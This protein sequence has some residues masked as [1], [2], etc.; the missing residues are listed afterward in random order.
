MGW[1]RSGGFGQA[2]L[3]GIST[4]R[5]ATLASAFTFLILAVAAYWP[6]TP[7]NSTHLPATP[8]GGY[9]FGD[10]A[11]MTWFLAWI[12]YAI[13]HGLNVFHTNYLDFPHGVNLAANTLSPLLGL[14]G[15]PVTLTLGPVATF[16]VLLRLA[17]ASSAFSM[18]W[19]LRHRCPWSISFVGGLAYGFGPYV[20]SQAQTHL[21]LAFVPLP[22]LILW[23]V[24]ELLVVRNRRPRRL[25]VVLGLL[26]GAQAL[27]DLELLVLLAILVIVGVVGGAVAARS[28]WRKWL[29]P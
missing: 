10:P 15:M 14:I 22:P 18:Y 25:G 24:Y 23:C 20:V 27:I 7:W 2:L 11:Q 26:A 29:S 9:S 4:S 1:W 16:N 21:D 6:T 28:N 19:V 8:Y 12:P 3:R 5:G 13:T 17:F